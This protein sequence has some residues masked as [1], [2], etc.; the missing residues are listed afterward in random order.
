MIE[1]STSETLL[2][3]WTWTI[4]L[5]L[6]LWLRTWTRD[7]G[8][9]SRVDLMDWTLGMTLTLQLHTLTLKILDS[10]SS[11]CIITPDSI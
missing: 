10:V 2:E 4:D 9:D 5:A 6:N 7:S 8:I 3:L 11:W 1:T